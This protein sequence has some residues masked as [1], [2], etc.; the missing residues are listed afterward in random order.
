[1][2]TPTF[3]FAKIALGGAKG[4]AAA[5][6]IN[7]G[8]FLICSATG[9]IPSDFLVPQANNQPITLVPVIISSILPL[10]IGTLGFM[11]LAK[12]TQ[13]PVMIF[14]IIVAVLV[15]LSLY[16]PFSIPNVPLGMAL[17]LN[18]M[19]IVAGGANYWGLHKT[20]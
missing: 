4:I 15:G 3:N 11:V 1:M 16:S 6:A 9:I 13:K 19:H 18:L 10:V 12:F 14:G 7:A 17:A 2:G 8:L 5:V 20:V